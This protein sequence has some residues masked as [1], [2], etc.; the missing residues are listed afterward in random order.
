MKRHALNQ[1]APAGLGF[2]SDGL[3]KKPVLAKRYDVSTRCIDN[4]M[5][6][7]VIPFHK[8]RGVVRFDIVKVDAALA[9]F[10]VK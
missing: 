5:S 4:W 6:A 9:Q 10:E 7:G 8:I 2:R 1:L 3:V